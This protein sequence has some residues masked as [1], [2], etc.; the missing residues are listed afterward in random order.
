MSRTFSIFPTRPAA[1]RR[2]KD[3]DDEAAT[4]RT[5]EHPPRPV[6]SETQEDDRPPPRVG[7][8][9]SRPPG[10]C[11]ARRGGQAG[12]A[13]EERTREQIYEVAKRKG[14]AGRSRMGKWDLIKA[15]RNA[16]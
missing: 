7:S 16:S 6:G 3:G 1:G 15:I 10:G 9:G 2:E 12:H 5:T 11:G 4:S 13:L 14:I 8:E